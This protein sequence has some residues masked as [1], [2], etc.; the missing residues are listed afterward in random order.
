MLLLTEM[1]CCFTHCWCII[2]IVRY[3]SQLIECV[4]YSTVMRMKLSQFT[5]HV[6]QGV[7]SSI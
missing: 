1:W 7:Q 6:R 3:L 5:A 4:Y 2:A